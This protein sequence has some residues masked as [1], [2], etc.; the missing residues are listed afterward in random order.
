M[1]SRTICGGQW[2]SYIPYIWT[3]ACSGINRVLAQRDTIGLRLVR[4]KV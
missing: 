4:R 2:N 1:S 3:R